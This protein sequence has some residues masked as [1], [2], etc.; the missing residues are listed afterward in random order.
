VTSVEIGDAGTSSKSGPPKCEVEG[1]NGEPCVLV[2]RI[3]LARDRCDFHRV[4]AD[5]Y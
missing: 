1:Q 3:A 2:Q 4:G 5:R